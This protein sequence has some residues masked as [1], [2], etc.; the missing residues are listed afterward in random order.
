MQEKFFIEL[1][2]EQ[3]RFIHSLTEIAGT[4]DPETREKMLR[5]IRWQEKNTG[6]ILDRAGM[7]E[8]SP[9]G[10]LYDPGLPVTALNIRK[11]S[12]GTDLEIVGVLEPAIIRGNEIVHRGVV[13]LEE[14]RK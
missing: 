14:E 13:I 1:A 5:Q 4:L 10:Q 6:R 9:K 2:I 12:D 3:Y 7:K 8:I 11:G